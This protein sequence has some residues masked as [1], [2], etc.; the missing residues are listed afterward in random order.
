MRTKIGKKEIKK[1]N[2]AAEGKDGEGYERALTG[3]RESRKFV[4]AWEGKGGTLRTKSV[5]RRM[6]AGRQKR[7]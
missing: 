6:E 4:S 1:V 7:K 3:E 2:F 5:E